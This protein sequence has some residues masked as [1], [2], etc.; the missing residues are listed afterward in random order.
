MK[1]FHVLDKQ[2]I[3]RKWASSNLVLGDW[4]T[5]IFARML[6]LTALRTRRRV[7]LCA[8][9]QIR[10]TTAL[11]RHEIFFEDFAKKIFFTC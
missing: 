5:E 6:L 7:R 4:T 9:A 1:P 2:S 3:S 10:K 8:Y 11:H